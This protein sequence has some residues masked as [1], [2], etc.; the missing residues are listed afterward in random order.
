M[1]WQASNE[2]HRLEARDLRVRSVKGAQGGATYAACDDIPCVKAYPVLPC[3]AIQGISGVQ[4][5]TS[6]HQI[7]TT[8]EIHAVC[9][10]TQ[11]QGVVSVTRVDGVVSIRVADDI[12]AGPC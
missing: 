6:D 9:S 4:R 11:L 1:E 5:H 2:G 8:A 7:I 10:R 12:C 3:A